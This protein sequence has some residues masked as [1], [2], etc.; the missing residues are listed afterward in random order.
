MN[1]KGVTPVIATSL[2]IGI[3]LSTALTASVFMQNSLDD[4]QQGFEDDLNDEELEDQS[5]LSIQYGYDQGGYTLLELRN[6]GEVALPL[7]N[8]DG[9]ELISLYVSGR[10]EE[11]WSYLSPRPQIG[12][13]ETIT[14]NTTQPF[15]NSGNDIEIEVRGPRDTS[16]S[17][18]CYND[19]SPS[20]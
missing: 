18:I 17:I 12:V 4:V 13:G 2:L 14:I 8:E 20:C 10:P 11:D 7:Q 16:S 9:I 5:D 6:S 1:R 3:A 19:G 15:P